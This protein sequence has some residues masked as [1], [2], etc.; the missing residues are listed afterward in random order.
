MVTCHTNVNLLKPNRHQ[1]LGKQNKTK[2]SPHNRILS[3]VNYKINFTFL[4]VYWCN[5]R[6][7]SDQS[8]RPQ[9]LQKISFVFMIQFFFS[10]SSHPPPPPL[11]TIFVFTRDARD[12]TN[13]PIT[14]KNSNLIIRKLT[15]ILGSFEVFLLSRNVAV[16][17]PSLIH[18]FRGVWTSASCYVI[19]FFLQ[20]LS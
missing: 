14:F 7:A 1:G 13:Q 19:G 4:Q 17:L 9:Y 6:Q 2:I 3:V 18:I 15:G 5:E 8:G 16:H 10:S 11:C 12:F 20:Y